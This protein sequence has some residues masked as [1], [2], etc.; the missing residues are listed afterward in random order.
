MKIIPYIELEGG[1]SIP[2]DI[3]IMIYM[4][5][6]EE[7]RIDTLF[8]N[9]RIG[10]P[11]EFLEFMQDKDNWP[12]VVFDDD[13]NV[14]LVAW[15]NRMNDGNAQV[16]FCT[17][18]GHNPIKMGK[19]LLKWWCDYHNGDGK[20]LFETIVGITPETY[21]MALK[22]AGKLGF[23]QIGTLPNFC[24]IE[25]EDRRVGGVVSYYIPGG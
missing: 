3:M 10:D 14:G 20:K 13:M 6:V 22:Y 5:M 2:V 23:N 21:H 15:L 17:F 19:A 9:N 1:W 11:W 18:K 4:K 8:Y 24:Y 7:G 12:A 16:H 25:S